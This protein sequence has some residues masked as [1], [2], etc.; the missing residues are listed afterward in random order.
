MS[1]NASLRGAARQHGSSG[2][3]SMLMLPGVHLCAA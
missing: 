1:T 2:L 3:P